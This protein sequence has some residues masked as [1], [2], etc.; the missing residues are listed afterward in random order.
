MRFDYTTTFFPVEYETSGKKRSWILGT[1]ALPHD[2]DET[3]L[4]ESEDYQE[5]MREV[6]TSGWELVTVQPSSERSL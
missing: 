3:S 2:P 5:H 6:G 1:A 4:I